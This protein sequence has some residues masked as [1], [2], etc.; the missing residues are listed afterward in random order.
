MC[1]FLTD[2]N[3]GEQH[4]PRL[5][6][7]K[8]QQIPFEK[9]VDVRITFLCRVHQDVV[10]AVQPPV[11][12][13]EGLNDKEGDQAFQSGLAETTTAANTNSKTTSA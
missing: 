8:G 11:D 6:I 2:K 13:K 3:I 9:V 7:R 10:Y 4:V 1:S 5:V 12:G